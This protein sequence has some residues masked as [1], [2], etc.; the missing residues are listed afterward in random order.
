[1]IMSKYLEDK[2]KNDVPGEVLEYIAEETKR[3]G[4][5]RITIELNKKQKF[6]DVVSER[7]KR[8]EKKEVPFPGMVP[9]PEEFREG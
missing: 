4:F 1:M 9:G 6:I 7:R 2:D 3:I 8:F 5:G